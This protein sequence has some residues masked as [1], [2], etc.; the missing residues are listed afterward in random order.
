MIVSW[1][2]LKDYVSL[3]MSVDE[4][5]DLMTMSGFNLESV[6]PVN[7][8]YA[9]DFEVTS[10]RRDCLGHIGIAREI[11]VLFD[12]P[13]SIP[14]PACEEHGEP[15]ETC[16]TLKNHCTDLSPHYSARI[17]KGVKVSESPDWLKQRLLTLGLQ[18]VNNIVDITNYV[19]METGQPLH[20]FD[21]GKLQGNT[22]NI[23]RA[24]KGEKLLSIKHT[25]CKLTEEMCIIADEENPVAIAGV[26]GG[27]ETEI[28]DQTIDLLIEVASFDAV[29]VRTTAR[30]LSLPSESSYR[31]GRTVDPQQIDWVSQ[32]CCELILQIAGGS[33][34]KGV[35]WDA[36][37]QE[38]KPP[39]VKIRWAQVSRILGMNIPVDTC[40]NFLLHLGL[41]VAESKSDPEQ[42]EYYFIPSWRNDLTREAD[43][44]EEIARLHGYD[45]IPE[46][47][48]PAVVASMPTAWQKGV[49]R[50][51]HALNS[52]GFF[53]AYTLTFISQE[54]FDSYRLNRTNEP[55]KVDHSTRR[56]ENIIR[57][58][59]IP[60]LL[61]S[62]REN[63]KRGNYNANLYEISRVFLDE[64][65]RGEPYQLGL[66]SGKSLLEL[67]GIVE[68]IFRVLQVESM[69]HYSAVE[70]P[71][72][73][74]GRGMAISLDGKV[75]GYGGELARTLTDSVNLQ[76]KVCVIEL[77]L[78]TVFS[79]TQFIGQAQEIS[80]YPSMMRDL[81]FILDEE[82]TWAMLG[83]TIKSSA[84][85][86]L[87]NVYFDSQ[88]RGKQIDANKKSYLIKLIYRSPHGTLKGEEVDASIE[89]IIASCNKVHNAELR[90]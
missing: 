18:P 54:M 56:K 26:M 9:I 84:G 48:A 73:S 49:E 67:K 33:L 66:V 39:M 90:A 22:I 86:L 51:H 7:D 70:F 15:I 53:E 35:L 75:I 25:E 76:E 69:I 88:Y 87:E 13:L 21:L 47:V 11:S 44:I 78:E 23:R 46:D 10:N 58:T 31:F 82:I 50:V 81:N 64:S 36:P 32:R 55:L 72:F 37:V 79:K 12:T 42:E 2:W 8:D 5:V 27:A 59:L 16:F 68:A 24:Q 85:E 61:N 43:L 28:S 71:E 65:A 45:K 74:P 4:M 38:Y 3:D 41:K 83:E 63:E 6:T 29:S 19:M 57:Q 60:S 80:P 89:Q 1:N 20:A 52:A 17:I 77:E 34:C 30:Q 14:V 62:L 40:R